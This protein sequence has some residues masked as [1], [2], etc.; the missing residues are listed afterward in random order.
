MTRVKHL[1]IFQ[2]K[3]PALMLPLHSRLTLEPANGFPKRLTD[4]R[5]LCPGQG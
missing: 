1:K 2:E 3:S 5:V 4:P